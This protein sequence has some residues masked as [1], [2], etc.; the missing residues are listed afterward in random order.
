MSRHQLARGREG[1]GCL[2]GERHGNRKTI[3]RSTGEDSGDAS[4][5]IAA[6]LVDLDSGMTLAVKSLRSDFDLTAASAYNSE[7]VKQKLKIMRTLGLQRHDRGHADLALGSDPPGEARRPQHLPL[8]R[9]GQE[10]E[11]HRDRPHRRSR[12]ISRSSAEP[13]AQAHERAA[14]SSLPSSGRS[15][16]E[17]RACRHFASTG[18]LMPTI[19]ESHGWLVVRIVYDGPA[20]SGKTT[21][22]RAL[23]E[24]SREQGREP[25]GARRQD[26][27]LRLDRLRRW[28]L[29]GPTDPLSGAECAGAARAR[30]PAKAPGRERGRGRVRAR[31][32]TRGARFRPR[33]AGRAS[34]RLAGRDPRRSGSF[35]RPTSATRKPQ[36]PRTSSAL[37]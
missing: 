36:S 14:I 18:E 33:V 20:L 7:L 23:A 32:A 5:F 24:R 26:A 15:G 31:H 25:G 28:P 30:T 9:G 34:S 29:R 11:Q 10:A 21:S 16:F 1:L 22:L 2:R 19:D 4:G 3:R 37:A 17:R 35:C 13:C 27:L 12:S 6:S 8:S